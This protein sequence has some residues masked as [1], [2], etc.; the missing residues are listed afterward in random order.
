[1]PLSCLARYN[2]CNSKSAVNHRCKS[3]VS[4]KVLVRFPYRTALHVFTVSSTRLSLLISTTTVV[5]VFSYHRITDFLS[6]NQLSDRLFHAQSVN[7]E[8]SQPISHR[9]ST[10]SLPRYCRCGGEN[11]FIS[12]YLL[13][14]C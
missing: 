13:H 14:Y 12:F 1:M 4:H 2:Y 7:S 8:H 6:L 11:C 9:N 10:A 3:V 5:Q